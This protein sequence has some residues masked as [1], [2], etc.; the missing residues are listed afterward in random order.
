LNK[1][2]EF[3]GVG[4]MKIIKGSNKGITYEGEFKNGNCHG[5]GKM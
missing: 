4:K 1:K 3:H 2:G 5:Y